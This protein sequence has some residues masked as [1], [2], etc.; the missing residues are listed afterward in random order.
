V[1]TARGLDARKTRGLDAAA[2]GVSLL[3]LVWAALFA[4]LAVIRH[5]SGGSHAE[6]LGFTDQV[7]ANLLRGPWFRMSVYAGAATWNTELDLSHLARPDSLLAFHVEPM[8]L[9]FVPLYA[10]GG[11][12]VWLLVIQAAAVALGALPAFV[13]ARRM[14]GSPWIGVAVASAYLLSPLGQW[15]VLS[16]FHTSTVAAPLLVLA[17]ERLSAGRLGVSLLATMVALSAREDVGPVVLGLSVLA[18]FGF[19]QRR[20]GLLLGGLGLGWSLV[21]LLVLRAYSGGSVSPFAERYAAIL[22]NGPAAVWAA[23][24]R[25]ADLGYLGTLLLSGGW[26]ALLSPLAWLPALPSLMLNL[27]SSSPWM[28][29]GR[30]HYSGL[31]L[32]FVVVVASAALARVRVRR[33][34]PVLAGCLVAT[35]GLSYVLAGAGPLALEYAPARL[36]EHAR[37]ANMLA[38][39][40]PDTAAVSASASLVPHVSRRAR[41]Y[42]FPA[43]LDADAL[44]LDVTSPAPTSAGDVYLRVRDLLTNGGWSVAHAQDGLL[45]L[46]RVPDAPPLAVEDL[47][48]A[49]VSFARAHWGGAAA[50]VQPSPGAAGIPA[51]AQPSTDALELID[52]RLVPGPDGGIEPDGPRGILRTRWLV[53]RAPATGASLQFDLSLSDGHTQ[54][55]WDIPDVWWYPPERWTPGETVSVDVP[56]VPM[57]QFRSWQPVAS[58]F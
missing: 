33:I 41:V 10:L 42:V 57:R 17:V 40:L 53:Q 27:L 36:T 19:K 24:S 8:L 58:G 56:N 49:F 12:V 51:G 18:A 16:D 3:A 14:T 6:D 26:L 2:L 52:A 4:W 21:C 1:R 13:L 22:A 25:P 43:V 30:A 20:F 46:E 29:S 5:L 15:A 37:L 35:S 9:L 34:R 7:I 38:A 45:L 23:L 55:V 39:S 47:P 11:G 31:V 32:P 48:A 44:L 54:R 50:G 28:A